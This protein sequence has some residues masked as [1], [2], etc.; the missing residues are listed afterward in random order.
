MHTCAGG[1][2]RLRDQGGVTMR[3]VFVGY[4]VVIAVGLAYMMAIALWHA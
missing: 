3:V 2:V 1:A 4:L